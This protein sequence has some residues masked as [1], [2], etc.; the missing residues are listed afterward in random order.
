MVSILLFKYSAMTHLIPGMLME[1]TD[2][3][4]C[5]GD[6]QL[7]NEINTYFNNA[8]FVYALSASMVMET[9]LS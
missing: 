7:K 4:A 2:V 9:F 3:A 5:A 6:A 1:Q 8:L